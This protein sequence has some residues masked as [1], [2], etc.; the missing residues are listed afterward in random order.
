MV[1]RIQLVEFSVLLRFHKGSGV[2]EEICMPAGGV[3]A[4]SVALAMEKARD[5]RCKW[6]FSNI[7]APRSF[8]EQTGNEVTCQELL[9][10]FEVKMKRLLEKL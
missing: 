6:R 8:D 9:M 3:D 1:G 5:R 7:F 10:L 2:I 4:S